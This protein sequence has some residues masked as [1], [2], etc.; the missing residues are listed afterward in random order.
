MRDL[1]NSYDVTD[2]SLQESACDACKSNVIAVGVA[3]ALFAGK[4]KNE[5]NEI[6]SFLYL[7]IA[8]SKTYT[9]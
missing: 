3:N 7:L 6:T 2:K 8:L 5:I 9:Q 4:S 1:Q